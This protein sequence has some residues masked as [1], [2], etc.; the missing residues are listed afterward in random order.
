MVDIPRPDERRKKRVR[1]AA[2]IVAGLTAV[3]LITVGVSRLK[4][5]APT[6]D[7]AT[8]W[9]DT[10]KRGPMLRQVRGTGTLVPEDSRWIPAT[11][12]GRVERIVLRPGAAVAADT[13]ILELSNPELEQ[14]VLESALQLRAAEAQLE[15]RRAELESQLLALRATTA[16]VEAEYRQARLQAEADEALARDGLTSGLT[17]KISRSRA[18]EL[19][20]RSPIVRHHADDGRIV[21]DHV[22]AAV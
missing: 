2:F 4:P 1:Q 22:E 7:R 16:Q 20:H 5:A 17:M 6:V 10:V 13:V 21:D 15:N 11:T 18:D 12:D 3:L 19:E 9:I 8:V 14:S